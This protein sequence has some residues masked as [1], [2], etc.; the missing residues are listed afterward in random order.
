MRYINLRL[1]YLLTR[2]D[3]GS[4]STSNMKFLYFTVS[5]KKI[6]DHVRCKSCFT[7]L[8]RSSSCMPTPFLY[9]FHVVYM[10]CTCTRKHFVFFVSVYSFFSFFAARC[11]AVSV[12]PSLTSMDDHD[13]E[14]RTKE[15]ICIQW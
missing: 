15:L 6:S 12:R 13:K 11:Y 7:I 1:T 8:V 9:H 14:K 3:Q 2:F 5:R 4:H 10:Y